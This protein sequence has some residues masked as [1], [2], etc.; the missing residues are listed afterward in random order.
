MRQ[1]VN[2]T[3]HSMHRLVERG[4]LAGDGGMNVDVAMEPRINEWNGG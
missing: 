4:N 3:W 1:S 2:G